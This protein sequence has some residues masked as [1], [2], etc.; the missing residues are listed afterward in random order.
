MGI[1]NS[2]HERRNYIDYA[3]EPRIVPK[4]TRRDCDAPGRQPVDTRIMIGEAAR[5]VECITSKQSL[6]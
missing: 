6:K 2:R 3:V 1:C 4:G 5:S